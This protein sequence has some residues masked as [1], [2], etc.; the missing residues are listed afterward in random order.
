M[1]V[2]AGDRAASLLHLS[3]TILSRLPRG[4]FADAVASA[5]MSRGRPLP[6]PGALQGES[7][8]PAPRPIDR[9]G[10]AVLAPEQ[11]AACLKARRAEDAEALGFLGPLPQPL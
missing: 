10:E 1:A 2:A 5:C 8:L 6:L 4:D 7:A 9:L 11:L 3:M